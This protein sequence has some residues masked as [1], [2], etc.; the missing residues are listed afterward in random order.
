V[1]ADLIEVG[2]QKAGHPGEGHP[3][4]LDN[5]QCPRVLSGGPLFQ[6]GQAVPDNQPDQGRLDSRSPRIRSPSPLTKNVDDVTPAS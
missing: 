3:R 6:Q 1:R 2:Q 5:E 4:A